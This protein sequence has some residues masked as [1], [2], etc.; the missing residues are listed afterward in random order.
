MPRNIVMYPLRSL[1]TEPIVRMS[2]VFFFVS[3]SKGM[4][5]VNDSRVFTV[6]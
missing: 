2:E 6:Y 5:D 3:S 4:L 1:S